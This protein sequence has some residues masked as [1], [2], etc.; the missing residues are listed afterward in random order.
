[1]ARR[2]TAPRRSRGSTVPVYGFYGENDA[3][4]NST[5]PKTKEM[6]QAAGKTYEP[7]I[8]DGAGHGFMRAGEAVDRRKRPEPQG[9]QRGLGSAGR[10]FWAD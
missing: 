2:P 10:R 7:V 5:I 9:P 1:M 4:I 3:R 6:M 8:Y